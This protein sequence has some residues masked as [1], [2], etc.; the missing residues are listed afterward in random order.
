[1]YFLDD[2]LGGLFQEIGT[3]F[4]IWFIKTWLSLYLNFPL[5]QAIRMVETKLYHTLAHLAATWIWTLLSLDLK[6]FQQHVCVK[7]NL[8]LLIDIFQRA[9][10]A[11]SRVMTFSRL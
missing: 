2:K 1:M 7:K 3:L 6:V 5:F 9:A 10:S 4:R 11:S 8:N